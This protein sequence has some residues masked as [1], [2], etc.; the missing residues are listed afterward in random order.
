MITLHLYEIFLVLII[1]F[2]ADFIVQTDW[3]AKNKSINNNALAQHVFSYSLCWLVP[4]FFVFW[5]GPYNLLGAIVMSILFS[6][7]TF[8]AHFATDY[9]TSR[10]NSKLW[11]AGNT[12]MFFVSVG[13]DQILH[14]TQLFFTYLLLKG[15]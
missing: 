3:Q 10:I 5:F 8:T 14:Y 1:H 12:H 13:F 4:M 7:I 2:V 9:I 15:A 6:S 11:K